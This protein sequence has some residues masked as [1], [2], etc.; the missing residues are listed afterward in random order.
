[1]LIYNWVMLT[2]KMAT[3]H[4][5]TQKSFLRIDFFCWRTPKY[6]FYSFSSMAS[7]DHSSCGRSLS[8]GFAGTPSGCYGF[9]T[10]GI[11]MM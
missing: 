10:G 2:L 1:M 6:C 7:F 11:V 9:A 5:D 4:L 8:D 3:P